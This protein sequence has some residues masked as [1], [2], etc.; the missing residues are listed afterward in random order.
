MYVE[1]ERAAPYLMGHIWA[2]YYP[3]SII[4]MV[5]LWSV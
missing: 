2:V 3:L 4:A 5:W 1:A